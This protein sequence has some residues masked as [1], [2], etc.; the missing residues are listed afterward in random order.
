MDPTASA[1]LAHVS[2]VKLVLVQRQKD[3]R[4]LTANVDP[5]ASVV[6]AHVPALKLVLVQSQNDARELTAN[7]NPT[8]SIL[9][10]HVSVQSN[11]EQLL[12]YTIFYLVC[13]IYNLTVNISIA[14]YLFMA[15]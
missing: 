5:T 1:L 6:L 7:A 12:A 13:F 3:A 2:A 11:R 9:L 14:K 4:E 15:L 10:A 8:A